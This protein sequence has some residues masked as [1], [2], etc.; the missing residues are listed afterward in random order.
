MKL[1]RTQVIILWLALLYC[2]VVAAL[3]ARSEPHPWPSG[4]GDRVEVTP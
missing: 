2:A 3:I 4:D 1:N